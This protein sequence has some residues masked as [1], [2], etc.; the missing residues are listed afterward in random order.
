MARQ[1]RLARLTILSPNSSARRARSASD[2]GCFWT[3]R[4]S[5]V[6]PFCSRSACA[7][8]QVEQCAS[9]YRIRDFIAGIPVRRTGPAAHRRRSGS[10]ARQ[11]QASVSRWAP[12]KYD[13][14][15]YFHPADLGQ[16]TNRLQDHAC[17]GG[18]A[19]AAS[20][21]TRSALRPA[22]VPRSD[23]PCP[24]PWPRPPDKV[25]RTTAPRHNS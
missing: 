15:G 19:P 12:A 25:H 14:T 5:T 16:V 1:V 17:A 13:G 20:P 3:S 10:E 22:S 4:K 8:W 18:G 9:P 21:P 7:F 6:Q 2:N 23:R 24:P 11:G